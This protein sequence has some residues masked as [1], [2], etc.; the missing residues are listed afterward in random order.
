MSVP[1]PELFGRLLS[2]HAAS[3]TLFARQ[4][5]AA[6][7]DVVQEEFVRLAGQS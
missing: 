7:E 1:G 4:W 5:C 6:P 2:E 3:L